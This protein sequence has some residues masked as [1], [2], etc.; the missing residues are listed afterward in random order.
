MLPEKYSTKEKLQPPP[1]PGI[2]GTNGVFGLALAC[3]S[4]QQIVVV[5]LS[6][7]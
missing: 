7:I 4:K 5:K 3:V 6:S 1:D 2:N